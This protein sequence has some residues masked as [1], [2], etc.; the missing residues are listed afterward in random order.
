MFLTTSCEFCSVG[1]KCTA[2]DVLL[3]AD[4]LGFS[5]ILFGKGVPWW[6]QAFPMCGT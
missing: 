5:M 1:S 2:P 4:K 6:I 3:V